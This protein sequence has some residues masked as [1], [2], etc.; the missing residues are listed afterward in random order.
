MV[1]NDKGISLSYVENER[2]HAKGERENA[3]ARV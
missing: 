3:R 1:N 2:L